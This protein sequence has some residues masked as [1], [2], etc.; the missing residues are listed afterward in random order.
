[1]LRLITLLTGLLAS[2]SNVTNAFSTGGTIKTSCAKASSTNL[3]ATRR[4]LLQHASKYITVGVVP[5]LL[6]GSSANAAREVTGAA[7]GNLPDLPFEAQRS[8]L[9]YRYPLQLSADFYIFDL[10]TMVGDTGRF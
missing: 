5:L 8:Y 9:Q 7:S 3:A 2:Y 4:S 1:M 6:G 10:Q